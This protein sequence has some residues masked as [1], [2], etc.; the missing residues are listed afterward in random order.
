[1]DGEGEEAIGFGGGSRNARRYS[2]PSSQSSLG[3]SEDSSLPSE[4]VDV[5]EDDFVVDDSAEH[6]GIP[7]PDIPLE[8]HPTRHA[9]LGSSLCM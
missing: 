2:T 8:L 1:M 9:S 5:D 6:I 4:N 7:H 3:S